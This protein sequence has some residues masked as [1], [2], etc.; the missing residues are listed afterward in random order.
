MFH[1]YGMISLLITVCYKF[2]M[3]KMHMQISFGTKQINDHAH[4]IMTNY[5][6]PKIAE[7]SAYGME[8]LQYHSEIKA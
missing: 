7:Y 1:I 4:K 8:T 6:W 2:N 3:L 5:E